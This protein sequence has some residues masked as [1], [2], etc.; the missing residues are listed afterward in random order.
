M[1]K[2]LS[3]VPWSIVGVTAGLAVLD[4]GFR[5]LA[6]YLALQLGASALQV[7]LLAAAFAVGAFLLA[8]PVGRVVDRHGPGRVMIAASFVLPL[9]LMATLLIDHV[10]SLL[11]IAVL[12]GCAQIMLVVA[13]QSSVVRGGN[14][15]QL[16]VIFGWL[17]AGTSVG[18]VL[19]PLAGLALPGLFPGEAVRTGLIIMTALAVCVAGM[20]VI[21]G[22]RVARTFAAPES[23]PRSTPVHRLLAVRGMVTAILVSGVTLAC[24]D[25]LVVFLPLWAEERGIGPTTVAALLAVRG[26]M[27]LVS[28]I[29][30]H[31]LVT[32]LSRKLLISTCLLLGAVGMGLLPFM[33]TAAAFAAMAVFG[34]CLGLVQP[35]TMTWVVISVAA[36]DRGSALGLRMLANRLM[37]VVM[38]LVVGTL[39]AP[40]GS[41]ASAS[42]RSLVVAAASLLAGGLASLRTSWASRSDDD[43]PPEPGKQ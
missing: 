26:A 41:F 21:S 39:A 22:I 28:R 1:T 24:L 34:F 9:A 38:P 5:P 17:S 7:G 31:A 29:G 36:S 19:G 20:A 33:G 12:F 18:Q 15:I 6:G 42:T 23:R 40:L 27:S 16:D 14:H 35:L 8:V 25:L 10:V 11:A 43:E 3:F 32:R 30:M 4:H 37:Q 13:L 2:T